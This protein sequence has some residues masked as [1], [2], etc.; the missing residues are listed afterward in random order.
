MMRLCGAAVTLIYKAANL[1]TLVV[2]C[3]SQFVQSGVPRVPP[4]T[5]IFLSAYSPLL[6]LVFTRQRIRRKLILTLP[7]TSI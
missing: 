5:A 3:I 7:I 6:H 1:Y 2:Y 4:K